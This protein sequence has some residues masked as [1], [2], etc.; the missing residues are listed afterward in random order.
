MELA[1]AAGAGV[2]LRGGRDRLGW[3][4]DY[5]DAQVTD[6][7]GRCFKL[8]VWDVGDKVLVRRRLLLII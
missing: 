5:M 4:R 2:Q 7:A 1:E 3:L 6:A 8:E